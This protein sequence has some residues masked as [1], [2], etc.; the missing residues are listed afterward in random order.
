MSW[1][2]SGLE[3][4]G[5]H[6]CNAPFSRISKN[7]KFS[8]FLF[9]RQRKNLGVSFTIDWIVSS[10]DV[11]ICN[12]INVDA[13]RE[14]N[15]F[16]ENKKKILFFFSI[17]S[18]IRWI[19]IWEKSMFSFRWPAFYFD[20][21]VNVRHNEQIFCSMF[22]FRRTF[23]NWTTNSIDKSST[24]LLVRRW[25]KFNKKN[26]KSVQSFKDWLKLQE[27]RERITDSSFSVWKNVTLVRNMTK[28]AIQRN[29]F[30]LQV[31]GTF[32]SM[33]LVGSFANF[34]SFVCWK[35]E[36]TRKSVSVSISWIVHTTSLHSIVSSISQLS[37]KMKR[38]CQEMTELST[39]SFSMC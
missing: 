13:D 18:K 2:R 10:L 36:Y 6:E 38:I 29:S 3:E 22:F 16:Y 5:R 31:G 33:H 27:E 26:T 19:S 39:R 21:C 32:R 28:K 4:E 8:F 14:K 11:E 12:L 24:R 30:W 35:K 9:W 7:E 20:L 1:E 15:Q 17:S 34:R 25:S 37:S 23:R